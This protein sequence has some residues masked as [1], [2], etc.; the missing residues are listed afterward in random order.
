MYGSN[1]TDE[2]A[3]PGGGYAAY[4]SGSDWIGAIIGASAS[5]YDSH[6]NRKTSKENVNKTLAAQKAE[7]EL[8]YQRSVQ[9]WN[10]QNMYN[11]PEAQMQRFTS[12][13]LNPHLIYGQGN[14]GN[15]SGF[16]EYQPAEQ[17][18][19]YEPMRVAPAIQ[20]ILPTLMAVGTWMQNMRLTEADLRSK[21]LGAERTATDTE[22]MRQIIDYLEQA[23]PKLLQGMENK[24]DLFDTQKSMQ[25]SLA[26]KA[27]RT[28]G[29]LE[30][31]Y[32]HK[33]GEKLV[34]SSGRFATSGFEGRG[35]GVKK[36]QFLSEAKKN[37]GLDYKNKLLEAQ[38]SWADMDIT[39]PQAIMMMVLNGVMGLAGASL[40]MRSPGKGPQVNS[41]RPH[42]VRR[43]HPS[44]RVQAE[45]YQSKKRKPGIYRDYSK[46]PGVHDFVFD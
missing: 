6:Q 19:A 29:D 13:G 45:S 31:E 1:F 46:G 16:P 42:G 3:T 36:L 12:A 40:R 35:D 26:E 44:R 20:S 34:D 11:S 18:Y 17:R 2:E 9:M 8:A 23:N 25:H 28:V 43:I 21:T 22:R 15:S 39:N 30:R 41:T 7:A 37:L 14:A 38:S 10:M 33:W 27:W 5:L 32:Q 24:L 4:G